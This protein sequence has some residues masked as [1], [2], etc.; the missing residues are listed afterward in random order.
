MFRGNESIREID[1]CLTACFEPT[2]NPKAP[3]FVS[4]KI[5]SAK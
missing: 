4:E 3:F 1:D 5:Y 2:G